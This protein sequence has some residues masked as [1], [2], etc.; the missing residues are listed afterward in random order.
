MLDLVP[1]QIATL[2]RFSRAGFKLVSLAHVERYLGLE[3]DGFVALL[4]PAEGKLRVF[5][6]VG[7]RMGEGIGMLVERGAGKAFVWKKESVVATPT[8]LEGYEHFRNE[9]RALLEIGSQQ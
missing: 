3:K 4:E 1:G 7:L 6:Q 2:E 9:V 5:G 8:L